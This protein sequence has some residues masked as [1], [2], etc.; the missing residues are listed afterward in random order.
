MFL[1][2]EAVM[3]TI[4]IQ[5][6]SPNRILNTMTLEEAFFGN[7]PSVEQLRTFGFPIYIHVPKDK[8]KNLEPL[9]K[10]GIFVGYSESLK[11]YRIYVLG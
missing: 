9:E 6:R 3:T 7:N 11:A 8:R 5:N 10:K 1:C 4:Y 2:G